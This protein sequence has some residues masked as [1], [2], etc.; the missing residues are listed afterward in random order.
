MSILIKCPACGKM[1]TIKPEVID[2]SKIG[3]ATLLTCR[4]CGAEL[5]YVGDRLEAIFKEKK[6]SS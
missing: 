4:N 3:Y 2:F 1:V 6:P 5:Q